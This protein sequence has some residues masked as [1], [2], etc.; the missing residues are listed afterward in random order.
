MI[1]NLP[2]S[3]EELQKNGL[4]QRVQWTPEGRAQ[5]QENKAFENSLLDTKTDSE[6]LVKRILEGPIF[7]A[8]EVKKDGDYRVE[9]GFYTKKLADFCCSIPMYNLQGAITMAPNHS[10]V[11]GISPWKRFELRRL[12]DRNNEDEPSQHE[13]LTDKW[14]EGKTTV[15]LWLVWWNVLPETEPVMVKKKSRTYTK[16]KKAAC[17]PV[18]YVV[19]WG[20][21][22]NVMSKLPKKSVRTKDLHLLEHCKIY[23]ADNGR[24]TLSN[25]PEHWITEHLAGK[26]Q[27]ELGF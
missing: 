4:P 9:T 26:S 8:V 1:D 10:E 6:A 27:L 15:F 12:T 5:W 11:K 17:H 25:D 14:R 23:K 20:D 24:W 16:W 22:L 2:P 3:Y 21:W 18:V 7:R 19:E 13:K